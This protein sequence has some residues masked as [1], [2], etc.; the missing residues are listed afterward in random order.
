MISRDPFR[1]Q[2]VVTAKT[3]ASA[4]LIGSAPTRWIAPEALSSPRRP[5]GRC[6]RQL[7]DDPKKRRLGALLAND[8]SAGAVYPSD[9]VFLCEM[10]WLK[11]R[12][13]YR[14][15]SA[16]LA[17]DLLHDV[18]VR[19]TVRSSTPLA[20][21]R[22]YL[23]RIADNLAVDEA[24]R[25]ARRLCPAEADALLDV[26]DE[27]PTA[28]RSVIARDEMRVVTAAIL[29]LPR[30]RRDIFIAARLSGERYASI[31]ARY[32]VTTRTVENEVRRAL[33]HCAARLGRDD[34]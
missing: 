22:A 20:A 28:E 1:K 31:A 4:A 16:E 3:R 32:G 5:R 24:R 12:L 6:A 34:C 14:T 9:R 26:A 18:W 29:E 33:D 7:S 13:R 30:R 11:R 8:H 21:P 17:E 25:H 2:L 19:L 15:G 23:T 27:S 10:A